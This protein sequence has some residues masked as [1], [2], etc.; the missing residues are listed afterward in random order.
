[1]PAPRTDVESYSSIGCRTGAGP[2]TASF[3]TDCGRASCI[4]RLI[5]PQTWSGKVANDGAF[6]SDRDG[7]VTPASSVRF[8]GTTAPNWDHTFV[9]P[10][11]DRD[12]RTST[13]F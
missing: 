4:T 11:Q 1:M 6:F 12:R 10:K 8:R 7:F 9:T 13:T 5:S 3:I 2:M